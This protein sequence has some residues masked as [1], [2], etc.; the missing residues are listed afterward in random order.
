MAR[1]NAQ[2]TAH[3]VVNPRLSLWNQDLYGVVLCKPQ[4]YAD[5]SMKQKG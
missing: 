4:S 3:A 1:N 5:Q 2:L